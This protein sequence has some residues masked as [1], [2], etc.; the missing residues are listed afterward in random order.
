MVKLT[1]IYGDG[2][3]KTTLAIGHSY[4]QYFMKKNILI[5]QFLKTGKDCGEC[6]F[7]EKHENLTWFCF[8]REQF[9][10]SIKQKKEYSEM[11]TKGIQILYESLKNTQVDTLVLDELGIALTFD[12]VKWV[13]ITELFRFVRENIIVTGREIPTEIVKIADEIIVIDAKKHPYSSGI[14]ARRGIDY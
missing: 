8:G 11:I 5:A 14:L 3:G 12:L 2:R 7:F 9:F 1:V 4:L 6:A 13:R 10:T